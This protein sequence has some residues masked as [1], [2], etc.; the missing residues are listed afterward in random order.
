M[1]R[2]TADSDQAGEQVQ[3]EL[4]DLSLNQ[5]LL[6]FEVANA[7]VIDLTQRLIEATAT[8]NDYRIEL[9]R[10]RIEHGEYVANFE[11]MRSSKGYR[12]AEKIWAVRR[13]LGV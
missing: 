4:N 7:R 10:L 12:L 1:A 5:A 11:R 9:D 8:V 6:D 3:R 2:R 13:A